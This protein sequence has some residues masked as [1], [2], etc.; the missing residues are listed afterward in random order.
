MALAD[1]LASLREALG[2]VSS[3]LM[4]GYCG[5]LKNKTLKSSCWKKFNLEAGLSET[6]A[7]DLRQMILTVLD[8]HEIHAYTYDDV[9]QHEINY[10]PKDEAS[11]FLAKLEAAPAVVDAKLFRADEDARKL[12]AFF[13]RIQFDSEEC[14]YDDLFLYQ[15]PV[16]GKL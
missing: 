8:E 12:S 14:D 9:L 16:E 3:V 6:I 15:R 4:Y 7:S 2:H 11:Q 1:D 10:L 5:N 13:F